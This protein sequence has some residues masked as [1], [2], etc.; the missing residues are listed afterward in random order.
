VTEKR[1][2]EEKFYAEGS[3]SSVSA[4]R[5]LGEGKKN[6]LFFRAKRGERRKDLVVETE[7]GKESETAV[8]QTQ[9]RPLLRT[10]KERDQSRAGKGSTSATPSGKKGKRKKNGKLTS[11]CSQDYLL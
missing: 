11:F 10:I 3:A 5:P 6:V 8:A 7:M 4:S 2:A 1:D 9:P